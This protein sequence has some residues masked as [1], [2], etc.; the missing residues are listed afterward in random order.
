MP[1][2]YSLNWCYLI[3]GAIFV[4]SYL[5]SMLLVLRWVYGQSSAPAPA[6]WPTKLKKETITKEK[7]LILLRTVRGVFELP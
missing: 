6:A 2:T 4:S 1:Q 3:Q 5:V 7:L